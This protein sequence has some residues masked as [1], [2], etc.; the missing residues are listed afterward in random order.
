M[1]AIVLTLT[2]TLIVAGSAWL[3]LGTR[4]ALAAD[5]RQNDIFNLL[6]YAAI[7]LIVVLPFVFFG[8]ERL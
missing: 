2:L 7:T 8:I 3:V 5:P 4:M 1:A 6:A